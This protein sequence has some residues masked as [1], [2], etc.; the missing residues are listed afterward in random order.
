MPVIDHQRTVPFAYL[1]SSHFLRLLSCYI[2]HYVFGY[3][4]LICPHSRALTAP[5]MATKTATPAMVQDMERIWSKRVR[6]AG[7]TAMGVRFQTGATCVGVLLPVTLLELE[8]FDER[9]MGYHRVPLELNEVV[10]VPFLDPILHYGHPDHAIF[11]NAKQQQAQ[12]QPTTRVKSAKPILQIWVYVPQRHIPPSVEYPIAQTYIDTILRGCLTISEEFAKELIATTKGWH[13]IELGE[14]C[15]KEQ[16]YCSTV[17]ASVWV[18]DRTDPLYC[19]GDVNHSRE[20]SQYLDRLL[21]SVRP[22][23]LSKRFCRG[24]PNQ[25]ITTTSQSSPEV[26]VER[27]R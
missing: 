8:Q 20:Y 1:E 15:L 2:Q 10:V 5:S 17:V 21:E 24:G 27:I 26:V 16:A 4:S 12:E 18:N 22:S 19:R 6:T 14:Y 7:M 23:Q 13:P 25:E 3:G 11:L 9:E